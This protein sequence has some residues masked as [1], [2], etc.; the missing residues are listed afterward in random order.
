MKR[1]VK[2]LLVLNLE[3]LLLAPTCIQQKV[4]RGI[5]SNDQYWAETGLGSSELETLL[6]DG[7]CRT[8]EQSFLACVNAVGQMAER[9]DQA[10]LMDGTL[11]PLTNEDVEN[12]L[13]EKKEL[14]RW[15]PKFEEL[16][17]KISFLKIWKQMDA[18]LIKPGERAAII[19][20]G[21]N[22]FLS[23][24]KDPHT[25]L[26]PL[27]MYEEVIANSESRNANAGMVARR[28]NG[29][30]IV[31]KVYEGSAA[32]KAGLRKGDHIIAVNGQ[33]IAGMVS[34]KI[35][36]ILKMRGMDR[37][38][39]SVMR[40]GEPRYLEI[41]RTETVF[42]SVVSKLIEGSH[43]I[44]LITIHKFS[45]DV[46]LSVRQKLISFKQQ[47]VAGILMDLRDNPG[48]QVEEAACV[49]N[50]FLDRGT[51]LFE[52][53]YLDTSK[54]S[55]RYMAENEKIYGGPLAILINSGS[56]SA[57]EIVA[58]A[59][60][61][62][63]RAKLVGE[64]SFGKGSFQDGRA[65]GANPKIALFE[66]EGFYYFASGWTPQLVGLQPDVQVNF[67]LSDGVRED[68]SFLNPLIPVDSWTGP[69]S[70]SWLT[71]K[72]CDLDMPDLSM[73]SVSSSLAVIGDDPQMQKAQALLNCGARND[74]NG[75]L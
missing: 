58:G 62:H 67:N 24:F 69:Q 2:A 36:D 60:R 65:W 37:M 41:L 72:E 1:L 20:S 5:K 8:D 49:A 30:L 39:L 53:R 45:K 38:G 55:D 59:L 26:M 28:V 74:R 25:Y 7:N 75:S 51:F 54:P 56:A 64:R 63:G 17:E 57:S 22:G 44:G 21:I 18:Q 43:N 66:T 27:A 35:S 34:A 19:A 10:L 11:R 48:G 68:E 50:L 32:D 52:T 15:S 16:R 70:L 46:C 42:P 31:R 4:D 14:S 3:I 29:E 6:E 47:R 13:T 9:L 73:T 61:D 12:R 40:K 23:I 71:E 33:T